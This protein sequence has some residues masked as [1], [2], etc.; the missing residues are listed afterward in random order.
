MID[1]KEA[2]WEV[3]GKW[4]GN[5]SN[6]RYK[7]GFLSRRFEGIVPRLIVLRLVQG[8]FPLYK[9]E[10]LLLLHKKAF[11]STYLVITK[12]FPQVGA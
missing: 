3:V 8:E 12:V 9:I 10:G 7:V 6:K 11:V 2:D 1:Q 5:C 4:G